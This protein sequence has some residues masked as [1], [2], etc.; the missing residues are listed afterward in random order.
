M[1]IVHPIVLFLILATPALAAE[2][3]IGDWSGVIKVGDVSLRL[4]LHVTN[5]GKGLRAT[6]DSIDQKVLGMPVDTIEVQGSQ[7][8][9][10]IAVIQASYTGTLDKAGTTLT[11]SWSQVGM[12]F[13][14][15]FR[16]T[17]PAKPVK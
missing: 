8:K 9:F 7:L 14:V 4:A 5:T 6:F 16:K 2:P 13:P 11:G 3:A 1:R 15:T 10:E 17:I 12:S